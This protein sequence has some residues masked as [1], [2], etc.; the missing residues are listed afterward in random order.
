MVNEISPIM[1]FVPVY[2]NHHLNSWAYITSRSLVDVEIAK[3]IDKKTGLIILNRNNT[4]FYFNPA[5]ID[6]D[7]RG[8]QLLMLYIEKF[9]KSVRHGA[10]KD[11][12]LRNKTIRFS[13]SE[14]AKEFGV[15]VKQARKMVI[16]ASFAMQ[17]MAIVWYDDMVN[18]KGLHSTNILQGFDYYED[19]GPNPAS[20]KRG[21]MQVVLADKFA[22]KLPELYIMWYPTSIRKIPLRQ[23]TSANAFAMLLSEHYNFKY[24][25]S[26]SNRIRV[27][28]L[29]EA[30]RDI[31]KYE[32]VSAGAGQFHKR[33][34]AP[35]VKNLDVLVEK[36]FL[37]EWH[38]EKDGE[39]CPRE[40]YK[41]LR[42]AF[43]VDCFVHF[44]ILDFPVEKKEK[45]IARQ[46]KRDN[47][48]AS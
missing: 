25:T 42:H 8:Q 21:E 39:A 1:P 3:K 19:D 24:G 43:F 34:V 44:E 46:M 41:K 29:L 31:P 5:H 9:T 28:L 40:D 38:L 10:S 7:G 47:A 12:I 14:I 35:F 17:L 18:R 27:P 48:S 22:L 45:S 11:E 13:V 26:E 36:G 6:I 37:K 4:Y 2:Q 30:T 33:I 32:K 15:T 16:K 23:Y 20:L